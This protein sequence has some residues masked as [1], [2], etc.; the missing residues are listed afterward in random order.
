[1]RFS[2]CLLFCRKKVCH[3][4]KV[5][6]MVKS[7]DY[8]TLFGMYPLRLLVFLMLYVFGIG[9]FFVAFPVFS[10]VSPSLDYAFVFSPLGTLFLGSLYFFTIC[11]VVF[12]VLFSVLCLFVLCFNSICAYVDISSVVKGFFAPLGVCFTR[13]VAF[14]ST[15]WG[16]F[17]G[18]VLAL[19]D[20]VSAVYDLFTF[21]S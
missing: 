14:L 7:S 15:V 6:Q 21:W 3:V 18:I 2:V 17:V 19:Y 12:G 10:V 13:L 1:M 4:F 20:V 5:L 8:K 16:L 11:V 9:L